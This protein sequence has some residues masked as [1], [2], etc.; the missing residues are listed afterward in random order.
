[1]EV[2]T[3]VWREVMM[4]NTVPKIREQGEGIAKRARNNAKKKLME[5]TKWGT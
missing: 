1:M 3:C 4:K 5:Q 2:Q